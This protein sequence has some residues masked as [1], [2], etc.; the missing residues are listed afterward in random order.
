MQ[1]RQLFFNPLERNKPMTPIAHH[2]LKKGT[3]FTKS[4]GLFFKTFWDRF[5]IYNGE[6]TTETQY[7]IDKVSYIIVRSY[8]KKTKHHFSKVS[9]H[10]L[11][12]CERLKGIKIGKILLSP[13]FPNLYFFYQMF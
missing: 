2:T 8:M 9:V 3:N 1:E 10:M 11:V 4:N 5:S 7:S 13:C 6:S 12:E